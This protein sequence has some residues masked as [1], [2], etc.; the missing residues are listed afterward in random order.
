MTSGIPV[1]RSVSVPLWRPVRGG[2][3]FEITVSRLAQT[4]RLGMLGAGDQ[5][6]PERELAE[7]L[8][9]SRVTLR[10]AIAA[11]RDAGFLETRRGRA[12]GTFVV[13][14]DTPAQAGDAVAMAKEMGDDLHDA[15]DFRRVVEPGAAALAATRTLSAVDR[16]RLTACLAAAADHAAPTRRVADSRLHLAIAA[17][18]GSAMLAEAV[19]PGPGGRRQAARRDPGDRTQPGPLRCAAQAHRGR[20]P[21]RAIRSPRGL[22]WRSTATAPRSCCA[23]YSPEAKFGPDKGPRGRLT[24][25]WFGSRP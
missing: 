2:N 6:P 14:Q 8:Q 18:S 4:I 10:E 17:A 20:D 12:G 22:P 25:Y 19:T 5:L 15:L 21:A 23:G 7:R 16:A 13:Y 3:A 9:V 24:L 11:L 1:Q